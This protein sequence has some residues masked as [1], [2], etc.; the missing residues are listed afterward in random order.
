MSSNDLGGEDVIDAILEKT[1][2]LSE[3]P[4]WITQPD[5]ATLQP[6][7]DRLAD[8][9]RGAYHFGAFHSQLKTISMLRVCPLPQRAPPR[10]L[11]HQRPQPSQ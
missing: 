4:I 11:H 8:K 9:P 6:F 5:R 10:Y 3:N 2:A 7:L 1:S